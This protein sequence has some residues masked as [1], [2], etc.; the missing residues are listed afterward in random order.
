M[1]LNSSRL[2]V[3]FISSCE[4]LLVFVLIMLNLNELVIR[5][6]MV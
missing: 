2:S 6:I 1:S 3:I 5:L 4:V